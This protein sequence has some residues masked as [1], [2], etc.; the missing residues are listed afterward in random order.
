V[1]F[2]GRRIFF[3]CCLSDGLSDEEK[4]NEPWY[5]R[6]E[7]DSHGI[8]HHDHDAQERTA[9]ERIARSFLRNFSWFFLHL[10]RALHLLSLDP[11]S[12]GR[13][14]RV[15]K[16]SEAFWDEAKDEAAGS[17]LHIVRSART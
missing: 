17:G 2:A 15:R 14:V 9:S 3:S 13:V 5:G 7:G 11:V 8:Q 4:G 1:N 16:W 6:K 10:L 12:Y